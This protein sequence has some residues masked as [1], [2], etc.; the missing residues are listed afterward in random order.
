[1]KIITILFILFTLVISTEIRDETTL[2][3]VVNEDNYVN[4]TETTKTTEENNENGSFI[5]RIIRETLYLLAVPLIFIFV[6]I[7]VHLILKINVIYNNQIE[8]FIEYSGWIWCAIKII[9]T[10][11]VIVLVIIFI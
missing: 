6:I 11:V 4:I 1:M 10:I 5:Y 2:G 9:Y 8:K 3:S 7:L